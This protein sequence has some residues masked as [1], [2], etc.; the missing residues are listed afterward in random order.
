MAGLVH[1]TQRALIIL[2]PCCIKCCWRQHQRRETYIQFVI[3]NEVRGEIFQTVLIADFEY[4]TRFIFDE[5]LTVGSRRCASL[6]MTGL[7]IDIKNSY[8]WC[9]QQRP[10]CK[11]IFVLNVLVTTP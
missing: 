10:S 8:Y 5:L 7:R 2:S 1:H 9:S 11:L 3:L 6:E 4:L